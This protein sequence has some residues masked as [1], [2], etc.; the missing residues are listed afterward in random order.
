MEFAFVK[1]DAMLK[2]AAALNAVVTEFYQRETIQKEIFSNYQR[3]LDE[4]NKSE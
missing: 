2:M 1:R 3:L 4:A